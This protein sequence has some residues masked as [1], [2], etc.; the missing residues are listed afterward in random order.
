MFFF[1]SF[2]SLCNE[3][4]NQLSP[5]MKNIE[6]VFSSFQTLSDR[7]R[8]GKLGQKQCGWGGC[9]LGRC[10]GRVWAGS[11][12]VR[13]ESKQNFTNSCAG[14]DLA[15]RSGQ[16]FQPAQTLAQGLQNTACGLNPPRDGVSSGRKDILPIIKK[17]YIYEKCINFQECNI[18][19]NNQ[20]T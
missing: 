18:S 19:W 11:L 1:K 5:S 13:V 14:L 9:V 20:I 2:R 6:W 12:R 7:C 4:M 10:A 17:Q 15:G 3:P 8:L 16:N